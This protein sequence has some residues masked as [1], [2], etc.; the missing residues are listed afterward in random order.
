MWNHTVANE[1]KERLFLICMRVLGC[2]LFNKLISFVSFHY[3]KYKICTCT[4]KDFNNVHTF[5]RPQHGEVVAV[6]CGSGVREAGPPQTGPVPAHCYD[7]AP[8]LPSDRGDLPALHGH[9]TGDKDP[10]QYR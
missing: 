4:F 9:G 8:T 7:G 3:S 5:Y 10:A 6:G 1:N 2:K